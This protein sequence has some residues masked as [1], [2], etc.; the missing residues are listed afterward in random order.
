MNPQTDIVKSELFEHT[1]PVTPQ[2]FPNV[3]INLIA[4]LPLIRAEHLAEQI[5]VSS[6]VVGGWLDNGYLPT[7]K[8]GKYQLINLVLLTENLKQGRVL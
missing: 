4:P 5:G 7:V 8:V 1:S 2:D 6:G 3:T